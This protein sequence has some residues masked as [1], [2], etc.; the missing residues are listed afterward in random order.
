VCK[1]FKRPFECQECDWERSEEQQ[2]YR[3]L[4][5]NFVEKAGVYRRKD[6]NYTPTEVEYKAI[7]YLFHEW[8]YGYE[9]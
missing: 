8:D 2:A 6:P 7:D 9:E 3:T 5:A 4:D 1:H